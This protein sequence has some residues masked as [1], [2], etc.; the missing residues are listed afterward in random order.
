MLPRTFLKENL[1][2]VIDPFFD[3]ESNLL[4]SGFEIRSMEKIIS[5]TNHKREK[6]KKNN[7][8]TVYNHKHNEDFN[9]GV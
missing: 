2:P 5:K 6:W 3:K 8:K 4:T 1:I 7:S 9:L